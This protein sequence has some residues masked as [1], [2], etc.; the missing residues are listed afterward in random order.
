MANNQIFDL[1]IKNLRELV[2]IAKREFEQMQDEEEKLNKR[3]SELESTLNHLVKENS[4]NHYGDDFN[5]D[6]LLPRLDSNKA[7]S[8]DASAASSC[9]HFDLKLIKELKI[10]ESS[11]KEILDRSVSLLH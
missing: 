5:I 1:D 6:N 10:L 11:A 9:K 7:V 2:D 4:C 3:I 8:N